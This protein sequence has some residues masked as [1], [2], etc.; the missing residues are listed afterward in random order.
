[1]TPVIC[2]SDIR[3]G[4][5]VRGHGSISILVPLSEAACDWIDEHLPNDAQWFGHGVVVEH[6]YLADILAGIEADGLECFPSRI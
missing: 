3:L 1:M 4:F 2:E 6:R 5:T